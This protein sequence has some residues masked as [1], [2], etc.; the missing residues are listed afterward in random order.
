MPRPLT[1]RL[2]EH[3]TA[4]KRIRCKLCTHY[5][6]KDE[7]YTYCTCIGFWGSFHNPCFDK[8]SVNFKSE[9]MGNPLPNQSS[10]ALRMDTGRRLK[11]ITQLNSG[12]DKTC[13]NPSIINPRHEKAG[14]DSNV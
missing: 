3:R 13:V 8:L 6:L 9:D 7:I 12:S 1:R 14:V 2:I 4:K 5:I 10:V 11:D